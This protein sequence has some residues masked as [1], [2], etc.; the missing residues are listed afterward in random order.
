MIIV[1]VSPRMKHLVGVLETIGQQLKES[2]KLNWIVSH[3][4]TQTCFSLDK[5]L[6]KSNPFRGS[7]SPPRLI[8]S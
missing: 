6:K 7:L 5:S 4:P 3:V 1:S 8:V 2:F